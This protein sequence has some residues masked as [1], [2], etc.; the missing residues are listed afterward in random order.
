MSW[1][2]LAEESSRKHTNEKLMYIVNECIY[3]FMFYGE[4]GIGYYFLGAL[5]LLDSAI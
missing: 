1:I 2:A 3:I 4:K 5:S